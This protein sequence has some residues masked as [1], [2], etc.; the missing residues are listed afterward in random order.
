MRK[1]GK[2]TL[3]IDAAIQELFT[4]GEVYIPNAQEAVKLRSKDG[5]R[6]MTEEKFQQRTKFIE[7]DFSKE[8]P[9]SQDYFVER[10]RQRLFSEHSVRYFIDKRTYYKLSDDYNDFRGE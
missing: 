4:K 10:F 7:S 3:L 2:T 9:G 6:G 5:R 8:F 1:T